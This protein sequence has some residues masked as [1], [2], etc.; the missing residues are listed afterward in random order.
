M[1]VAGVQIKHWSIT[2]TPETHLTFTSGHIPAPQAI[3]ILLQYHRSAL[4]VFELYI[5]Q[6]NQYVSAF[7][8]SSVYGENHPNI[9]VVL[10]FVVVL[11][12][13]DSLGCNSD[14]HF[15]PVKH[16]D[17]NAL[18]LG[19]HMVAVLTTQLCC[20]SVKAAIDDM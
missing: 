19:S 11:I 2:S 6:Q 3:S 13:F 14:W 8:C 5:M 17:I 16:K 15:F 4:P 1:S 20:C 18:S 7:F 12:C 10:V 9:F